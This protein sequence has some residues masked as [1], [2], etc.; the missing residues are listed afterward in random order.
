MSL[1]FVKKINFKKATRTQHRASVH[2]GRVRTK[3]NLESPPR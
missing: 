3:R 1:M 2:G